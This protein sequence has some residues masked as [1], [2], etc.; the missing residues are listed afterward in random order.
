MTLQLWTA[1]LILVLA[2]TRLVV[3]CT[4][5]IQCAL[6]PLVTCTTQSYSSQETFP[7]ESSAPTTSTLFQ[8]N[9]AA[10]GQQQVNLT[11]SRDRARPTGAQPRHSSVPISMSQVAYRQYSKSKT[12]MEVEYDD[13]DSSY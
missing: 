3:I 1:L 7:V 10:L 11:V 13:G 5:I 12:D 2:L 6:A 8:Q 4:P 9:E